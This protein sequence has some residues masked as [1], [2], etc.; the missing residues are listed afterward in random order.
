VSSRNAEFAFRDARAM[1]ANYQLPRLS[2]QK[3][4]CKFYLLDLAI[5]VRIH[6]FLL[7]MIG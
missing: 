6:Q 1:L 7:A 4:V 2:K 3:P 5:K